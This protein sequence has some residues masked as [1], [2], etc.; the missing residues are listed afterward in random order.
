ML[1]IPIFLFFHLLPHMKKLSFLVVLMAL[2]AGIVFA[3]NSSLF[4]DTPQFPRFPTGSG[5]IGGVLSAYFGSD[6]TAQNSQSLSGRPQSGYLQNTTCTD[7]IENSWVGIDADGHA[8]C[9]HHGSV[10]AALGRFTDIAGSVQVKKSGTSTWVPVTTTDDLFP[11]DTVRTDSSGTGTIRFALD[12][13]ILRLSTDTTVELQVGNLDGNSVAEALLSDGRLWAR[14]LTNTG[15]IIGG[16]GIVT[17]VRG[18]SVDVIKSGSSYTLTVPDSV[19]T[20]STL[21][22]LGGQIV[23][24]DGKTNTPITNTSFGPGTR[25]VYSS[26]SLIARK[27]IQ[28]KNTFYSDSWIARN[29]LADINYMSDVLDTPGGLDSMTRAKLNNE[30]NTTMAL[31]NTGTLNSL[32]AGGLL[33]SQYIPTASILLNE[34]NKSD[35]VENVELVNKRKADRIDCKR[36]AQTYFPGTGDCRE[37][38]DTL[39]FTSFDTGLN[40]LGKKDMWSFKADEGSTTTVDAFGKHLTYTRSAGNFD[41][42]IGKKI[43]IEFTGTPVT[44]KTLVD[45]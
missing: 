6:G 30:L 45:F 32:L 14:V 26:G 34:E 12:T 40:V 28:D 35:A 23:T 22:A 10:L 15:V 3:A 27:Y 39:A 1:S 38:W 44:S 17:G 11:G 43:E 13:S 8:I 36:N 24:Q 20:K 18:T 19:N 42:L 41:D 2:I 16:G 31:N 29:T 25:F 37:S 5:T 4:P 9:G 7:P 33:A 21:S